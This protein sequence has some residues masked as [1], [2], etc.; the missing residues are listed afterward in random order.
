MLSAYLVAANCQ[1]VSE[2]GLQEG[3][4]ARYAA[5]GVQHIVTAN[6]QL[7]S[8]EGLQALDAVCPGLQHM[9]VANCQLV[10]PCV[11]LLG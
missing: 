1:L 10:L 3:L 9:D 4:Q 5:P 11:C 6:G 8:E 7:I 2:E